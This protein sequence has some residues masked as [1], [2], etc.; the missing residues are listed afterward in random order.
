MDWR[1]EVAAWTIPSR[2]F[3]SATDDK[4]VRTWAPWRARRKRPS[5]FAVCQPGASSHSAAADVRNCQVVSV[6][7]IDRPVERHHEGLLRL[8]A[9]RRH[10]PLRRHWAKLIRRSHSPPFDGNS[11]ECKSYAIARRQDRPLFVLRLQSGLDA[12][13]MQ[14]DRQDPAAGRPEL[15]LEK[16]LLDLA[17]VGA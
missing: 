9:H 16:R 4:L 5:A 3:Q 11:I 17:S 8:D 15:L 12:S 2:V 13:G 14:Q 10:L 1:L 7:P 6:P